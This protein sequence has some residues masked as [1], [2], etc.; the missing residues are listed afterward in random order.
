MGERLNQEPIRITKEQLAEDTSLFWGASVIANLI[1]T[2]HPLTPA[3]YFDTARECSLFGELVMN[4]LLHFGNI[5]SKIISVEA[6]NEH[7]PV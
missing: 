4:Y 5:L 7:K 2:Q 6:K 1:R 3:I